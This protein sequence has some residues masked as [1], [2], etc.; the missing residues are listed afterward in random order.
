MPCTTVLLRPYC[1]EAEARAECG[2]SDTA[3]II[4]QA[5]RDAINRASRH[6]EDVTKRDFVLHDHTTDPLIINPKHMIFY[7]S[8]HEAFVE[9]APIVTLVKVNEDG[10]DLVEDVD[11]IV[12]YKLGILT[13][14]RASG[15]PYC[16]ACPRWGHVVKFYGKAGFDNSANTAAPAPELAGGIR[17]ACVKIAAAWSGQNRREQVGFDGKRFA[18]A[19][20]RIPDDAAKLLAFFIPSSL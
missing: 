1:T 10:V 12:D 4:T 16:G 20:K 7:G 17:T 3:D 14:T 5:F 15:F 13:R 6:I 11:F 8:A 19:D 2:N 9:N 18:I